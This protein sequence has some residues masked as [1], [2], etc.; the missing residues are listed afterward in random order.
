MVRSH[1][2]PTNGISSLI[3]SMLYGAKIMPKADA[4]P[5]AVTNF[6][7]TCLC[8][9]LNKCIKHIPFAHIPNEGRKQSW[10]SLTAKGLIPR[11]PKIFIKNKYKNQKSISL[12]NSTGV[13]KKSNSQSRLLLYQ[14]AD[15]DWCQNVSTCCILLA[16]PIHVMERQMPGPDWTPHG[17]GLN[18]ITFTARQH[19]A[20]I[21]PSDHQ[22][23]LCLTPSPP[24]M[25]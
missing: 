15:S 3:T 8:S 2:Q 21:S 17:R 4:N 16:T 22:I 6:S 1:N 25:R 14:A 10:H 23:N 11:M 24:L 5:M 9:C 19:L 18:G 12:G 20:E 13:Q 7:V